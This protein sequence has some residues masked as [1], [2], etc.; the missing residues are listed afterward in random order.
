MD[1]ISEFVEDVTSTKDGKKAALY[2]EKE[3]CRKLGKRFH[4]QENSARPPGAKQGLRLAL[5]MVRI[6]LHVSIYNWERWNNFG[7]FFSSKT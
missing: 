5:I 6:S 4:F 3:Q 1:V 7:Q 2:M